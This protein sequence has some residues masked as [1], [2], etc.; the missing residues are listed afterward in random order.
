MAW[1]IPVTQP[2]GVL[3][4]AAIWNAQ[5]AD[6]AAYL[7]AN[8][9]A[10]NEFTASVSI[11]AT[12]EAT[13]NTVVTASAVTFDGSTVVLIEAYA[14]GVSM[15]AANVSVTSILFQDGVAIGEI[16]HHYGPTATFV[17]E[18]NGKRR[19]T[20]AAGA[21]TYSVRSYVNA[22]TGTITVGAGGAGASV[23]GFIRIT[24]V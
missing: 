11:T 21:R 5:V 15:S 1:T 10:Y 12:T 17:K 24:K 9:L 20:P 4:T 18:L 7:K 2:T 13:A 14:P 6:N 19:L 16:A 8:E 3:I 23:P 22:G